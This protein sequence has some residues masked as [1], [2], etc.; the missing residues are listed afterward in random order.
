MESVL[1]I[2][3]KSVCLV[4]NLLMIKTFIVLVS[5]IVEI[6]PIPLETL[7]CLQLEMICCHEE[8]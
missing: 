7:K 8:K 5:Y 1:M 4:D 3:I 6:G 2:P